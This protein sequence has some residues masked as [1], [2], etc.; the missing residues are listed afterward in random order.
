MSMVVIAHFN[1]P[2]FAELCRLLHLDEIPALVRFTVRCSCDE[3]VVIETEQMMVDKKDEVA[4]E[5]E[6][7]RKR[8]VLVEEAAARAA[9]LF[10][11]RFK[12]EDKVIDVK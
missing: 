6:I 3:A 8:Y 2:K 11:D 5:F 10:S 1:D 4:K 9:G 12:I 7:C